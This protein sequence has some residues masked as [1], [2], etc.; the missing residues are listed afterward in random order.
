[1]E[2]TSDIPRVGRVLALDWGAARIG[3]AVSDPTQMLATPH[4]TLH[5]KDKGRQVREAV[6]LAKHLDVVGVVVGLP[7]HLD[8][9]LGDSARTSRKYAEQIARH[10]GLPIVMVDERF[11]S[12]AAAE[13]L[14]R[15]G[16][17]RRRRGES[18]QAWK[19]RVDAAAAAVVLQ[20][21]LDERR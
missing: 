17:Q 6:A 10:S 15:G 19:G 18:L 3:I 4:S 13:M 5:T 2:T 16:A 1:M 11:S 20:D 21:W 9:E 12:V 8:G 7:L 14:R